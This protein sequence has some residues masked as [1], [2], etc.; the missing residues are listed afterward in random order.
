MGKN[1]LLEVNR[2]FFFNMAIASCADR[3]HFPLGWLYTSQSMMYN[4][5]AHTCI[6]TRPVH[7]G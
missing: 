5:P 2:D 6:K 3:E 7:A 4:H 1:P